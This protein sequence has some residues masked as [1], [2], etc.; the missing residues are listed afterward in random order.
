MLHVAFGIS[1]THCPVYDSSADVLLFIGEHIFIKSFWKTHQTQWIS[2]L[3]NPFG[4][5]PNKM[6][7]TCNGVCSSWVLKMFEMDFSY[8][9]ELI[10]IYYILWTIIQIPLSLLFELEVKYRL[11]NH[12]YNRVGS[13]FKNLVFFDKIPF[14]CCTFLKSDQE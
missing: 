2:F 10:C 1:L 11:L 9:A 6:I 4:I 5:I 3:H 13:N 14:W 8:L 12:V 7:K